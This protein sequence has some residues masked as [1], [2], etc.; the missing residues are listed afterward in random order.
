MMVQPPALT[1]EM[2]PPTPPATDRLPP[3]L[4]L[5]ALFHALVIL[6]VTF[7]PQLDFADHEATTLDV[8]ILASEDQNV[9]A[10]EDAELLAQATQLG[11]GTAPDAATPRSSPEGLPV[12]DEL[13]EL[14][15]DVA[16][17]FTLDEPSDSAIVATLSA[18]ARESLSP[19][20][21]VKAEEAFERQ[22]LVS[23][24]NQPLPAPTDDNPSPDIPDDDPR[25][26]SFSVDTR[27][28]ELALYLD[29]W[30]RKVEATGTAY[31]REQMQAGVHGSP[32]IEVAVAADGALTE[33]IVKRSSGSGIIDQAALN[34]LRRAAPYDPIPEALAERY[35]RLRFEYKFE[36]REDTG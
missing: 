9:E 31:L 10:N 19:E 7:D 28:S 32:V 25:E 14:L 35:D 33:I 4:F 8:I 20:D 15:G 23:G 1:R 27:E 36:F 13:S 30:K 34:V 26:L 12:P 2:L 17:D 3:M 16:P 11:A 22:A 6:G 5:A 18:D 29:S 24:M 21:A